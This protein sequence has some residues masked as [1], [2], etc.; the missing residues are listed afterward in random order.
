MKRVRRIS[1]SVEHREVSVTVA[2]SAETGEPRPLAMPGDAAQAEPCPECGAPWIT[3][4]AQAGESGAAG[5]A[6][7]YRTLQPSGVHM[8]ISPAGELRICSKS[9]EAIG[10]QHAKENGQ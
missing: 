8:Q 2:Q 10:L 3:V 5:V 6:G 4:A 1:L 9:L 7:I